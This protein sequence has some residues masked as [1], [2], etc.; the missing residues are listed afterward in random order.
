[1]AFC[2]VKWVNISIFHIHHLAKVASS[3]FKINS[4]EILH[5]SEYIITFCCHKIAQTERTVWKN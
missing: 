4:F 2:L 1:M 5:T 3:T